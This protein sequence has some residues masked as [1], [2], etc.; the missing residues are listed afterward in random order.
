M[1]DLMNALA[2]KKEINIFY[3]HQ[4]FYFSFAPSGLATP[5][6]K[7]LSNFIHIKTLIT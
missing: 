1:D 6:V 5:L 3:L 2:E 4:C 7:I